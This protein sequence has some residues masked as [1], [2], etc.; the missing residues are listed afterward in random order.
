MDR[1]KDRG[2]DM[3]RMKPCRVCNE[4]RL[5]DKVFVYD[6]ILGGFLRDRCR[7]CG[8]IIKR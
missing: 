3:K 5:V 8:N 4:M 6:D 2:L 7:F 1:E